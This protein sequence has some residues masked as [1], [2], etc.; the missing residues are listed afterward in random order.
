MV[1]LYAEPASICWV[2]DLRRCFFFN[3][4]ATT[5]IYTLSL[6]DALPI[7]PI[8]MMIAPRISRSIP[9]N[10]HSCARRGEKISNKVV[11][12]GWIAMAVRNPRLL[13]QDSPVS[14]QGRAA[15]RTRAGCRSLIIV[16]R[17]IR[18]RLAVLWIVDLIAN[19]RRVPGRVH[20]IVLDDHVLGS[21]LLE[22]ADCPLHCIVR[23]GVDSTKV[24]RRTGVVG[25]LIPVGSWKR[26]VISRCPT[27]NSHR[28]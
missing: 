2:C 1:K 16:G 8:R 7:Y 26:S 15:A 27:G 21:R 23:C 25:V 28:H 22:I 24:H 19:G 10:S 13:L 14:I 5:E 20:I 9:P 12:R 3:D 4:P 11:L 18:D 17:P 6:H